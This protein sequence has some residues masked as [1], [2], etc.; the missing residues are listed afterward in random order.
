MN[1]QNN[2]KDIFEKNLS[3]FEAVSEDTNADKSMIQSKL[4]VVNFDGVK[5]DYIKDMGLS[6]IPCSN[7][8]LYIDKDGKYYFI[9]FKNGKMNKAIIY[10]VYNKI[11]DSLLIFNDLIN[12]NIS[13]CRENVYF[14]LVYNKDKNPEDTSRSAIAASISNKANKGF[15][16]F[17]LEKFKKLY[18]REVFTYTEEEFEKLFLEEKEN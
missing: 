5:E 9:E 12:S 11:Y 3:T 18:F 13:F 16:R 8:A 2:S 10:N 14:I 6:E 1:I 4:E 17:G 15:I 7:D